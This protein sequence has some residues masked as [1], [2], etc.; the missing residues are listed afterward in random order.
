MTP[1]ALSDYM[2]PVDTVT[3]KHHYITH[4]C[5]IAL[6]WGM[7]REKEKIIYFHVTIVILL[8]TMHV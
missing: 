2:S 6:S 8:L 3:A 5:G 1:L 4:V 7:N